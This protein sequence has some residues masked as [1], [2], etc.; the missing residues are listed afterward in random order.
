MKNFGFSYI[1][2]WTIVKLNVKLD[3]ASRD[4]L[5][6]LYSDNLTIYKIGKGLTRIEGCLTHCSMQYFMFELDRAK[7][8]T[9]QAEIAMKLSELACLQYDMS[10]K[11]YE[12]FDWE[13][14]CI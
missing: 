9:K 1:G 6:S 7:L 13:N 12:G 14:C 8:L 4:H 10:H 2:K 11:E 5:I 3:D